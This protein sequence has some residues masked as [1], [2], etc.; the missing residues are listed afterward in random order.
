MIDR[1]TGEMVW[2]ARS[3]TRNEAVFYRSNVVGY[4]GVREPGN[5]YTYA[6]LVLG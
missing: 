1:N 6:G 4:A 5:V 3:S 2:Q